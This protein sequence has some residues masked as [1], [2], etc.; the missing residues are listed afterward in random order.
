MIAALPAPRNARGMWLSLNR[1]QRLALIGIGLAAFVV[2]VAFATMS[3]PNEYKAAFSNL[4]DEDAAAVVA[5]LKEAKVPYELDRGTIK[6]PAAQVEEA[7]LLIAAAGVVK[8]GGGAGF[9]IF[10][11]PH[12]GLTE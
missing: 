6:V 12:F 7:K 8:Q 4:K 2:V 11:Q 9:E 3:R 5:K 10:S 1:N